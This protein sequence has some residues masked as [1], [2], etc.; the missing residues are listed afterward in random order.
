MQRS[1]RYEEIGR[2]LKEQIARGDFAAGQRLP[3]ERELMRRY[4][5]HRNT[6]RQ[7]LAVL[8]AE[9]WISVEPKR[10]AFVRNPGSDA[11][12]SLLPGG[13]PTTAGEAVAGGSVLVINAW[14]SASTALDGIL[15]GLSRALA[16]TDI[17]VLRFDSRPKPGQANG[18]TP[19]P[20]YL[21]AN[22]TVGAVLWPHGP[23]DL[24]ALRRLRSAAPLVL[25][26]RR[27]PGF[28][29]DSVRFDDVSG[30][31]M[32]TEHLLRRGHRRI[33]FLGDDSF[34]ETVQQRW[35]GYTLALEAAGIAPDPAAFA[36]F[37]GIV[38][39]PF[40]DQARLFLAGGGNP[41]SA[42]VCSNDS[43]ALRLLRFLRE[44]GRRVPEDL[45]VTGYGNLLPD[46][47]DALELTTVAQPF[48]EVGRVAGAILLDRLA[49]ADAVGP[50]E[51]RSVELP[52]RLIVRR[53]SGFAAP[54]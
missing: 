51:Y 2:E 6:A 42:V 26:D 28:E 45:A 44:D 31:R 27:V 3:S 15:L 10:G 9:G 1:F 36:L 21:A 54:K 41:L 38:D 20:A 24:E 33:G 5:V 32:V 39:P 30:G 4:A 52:V 19:T 29:T 47:L 23:A 35:R 53:S 34:A 8:E 46:Y 43:T 13:P 40:A 48:E 12:A 14:N 37:N 17:S 11:A 7:A 49:R 18:V 16:G 50:R 25:V 22:R